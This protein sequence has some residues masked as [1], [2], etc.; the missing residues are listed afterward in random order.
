MSV[1]GSGVHASSIYIVEICGQ[2]AASSLDCLYKMSATVATSSLG[3]LGATL[4][5]ELPPSPCP[6]VVAV[7]S[8]PYLQLVLTSP[9]RIQGA[10][11]APV[12]PVR[13]ARLAVHE[14]E[15]TGSTPPQPSSLGVCD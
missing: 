5:V 11:Y 6:C 2:Q 13:P 9:L 3:K 8:Q 1:D 14:A 7:F 4:S 10:S 12:A 15:V